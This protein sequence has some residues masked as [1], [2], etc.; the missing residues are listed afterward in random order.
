MPAFPHFTTNLLQ[1]RFESAIIYSM[2]IKF[3]PQLGDNLIIKY[4]KQ[5]LESKYSAILIAA[6]TLASNLF[7]W[8]IPVLYA[9]ALIVALAALLCDDMLCIIPLACCAYFTFSKVNNPLDKAHTSIFLEKAAQVNFWIIVAITAV[10]AIGRLVFDIIEHKERRKLPKLIWG[11]V[12]LGVA[13]ILGGLFSKYYAFDTAFFGLTQILAISFSY[14]YFYFTVDFKKIDKS[15]F[16]YLMTVCGFLLCGEVIGMLHYG[17]FF[18]TTG[19]F[20]RSNLHTGWGVY[21]NVA[22]AMIMCSPAPF[23]YATTKDRGWPYR[24]I[25]NFFY[26]AILF[27]QSRGGMLFGSCVYALCVLVTIWKTAHKK[28]LILSQRGLWLIAFLV[29]LIFQ[30]KIADMFHSVIDRGMDDSGR[31]DIYLNGLEQFLDAPIFGNGFYACE[32]FRWGDNTIGAFLPARYHNTVVQLLASGGIVMLLAYGYHRF[33]TLRMIFK[34]RNVE[35]Y[36]I[37]MCILGLLLTSLLDCHFFNFGPGFTYSALLLLLEVDW[38]REEPKAVTE[39]PVAE[40]TEIT[41]T[42]EKSKEVTEEQT[43]QKAEVSAE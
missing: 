26:L 22:G 19:E 38:L 32:S 1:N 33:E 35:K 11:F 23:Y 5:A 43:E 12:A 13:Y 10:F 6:L 37:G 34:K 3:F 15:Y 24:I 8:E 20:D 17:G 30:N 21:N 41:E 16:A 25:G 18:T 7:S 42:T 40:T 31:F 39:T 29:C 14:F 9:F 2:L 28:E 36:F 27:I 4:L